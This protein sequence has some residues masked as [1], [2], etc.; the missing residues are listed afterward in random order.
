MLAE[1]IVVSTI[2]PP[3]YSHAHAFDEVSTAIAGGL[4]RLGE[5][6]IQIENFV[7]SSNPTILF[8]GHLLSQDILSQLP[9]NVI[10]FNLEQADP[11]AAW[12]QSPYV[13]ALKSHEVWDFSIT[14]VQK[15]SELHL[16]S[17]IKWCPIGYVSELERIPK[18][19]EEDIDVLFYGSLNQRRQQV[20]ERLRSMDLNVQH[21]FGIYGQDRDQLIARSKVVL[22]MH[23]YDIGIFEWVRVFYLLINGRAVVSEASLLTAFDE[24]I[25]KI[26]AFSPYEQLVDTC[27]ALARD[28]ERREALIAGIPEYFR[29]RP[30]DLILRS[31]LSSSLLSRSGHP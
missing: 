26:V 15:L 9:P 30:Q 18:Q 28:R 20:L 25:D 13:Q 2:M 4:R 11:Q 7:D 5:N 12:M 10:F 19:P 1:K 3:N 31:V 29:H 21:V 16:S 6:V 22:N 14:N 24:G 17:R 8:G 27:A 23:F